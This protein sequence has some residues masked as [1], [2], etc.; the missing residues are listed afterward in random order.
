M[1]EEVNKSNSLSQPAAAIKYE[2]VES[3]PIPTIKDDTVVQSPTDT[4]P[5]R[6]VCPK[7]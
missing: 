7:C 2:I 3:K 6:V 4:K 1:S 5:Q